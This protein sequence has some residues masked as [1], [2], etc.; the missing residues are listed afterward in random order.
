MVDLIILTALFRSS[1]FPGLKTYPCESLREL[2]LEHGDHEGNLS[3][4]RG[5]LSRDT[6]CFPAV[7][8]VL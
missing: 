4:V 7:S 5:S 1:Q 8:A 3:P 2:T 6:H